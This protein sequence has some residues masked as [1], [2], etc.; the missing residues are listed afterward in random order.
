M[1][2]QQKC[3]LPT[4]FINSRCLQHH[5]ETWII[6]DENQSLNQ[7]L[8]NAR[9]RSASLTFNHSVYQFSLNYP[10]APQL[11]QDFRL[12]HLHGTAVIMEAT[13]KSKVF[14]GKYTGIR[15]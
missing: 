12:F 7:V 5:Q 9:T 3:M 2:E 15:S 4:L 1:A 6:K 8:G 14:L 13:G 10:S 11:F